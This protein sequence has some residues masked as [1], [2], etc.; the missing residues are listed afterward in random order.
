M[1]LDAKDT[2]SVCVPLVIES[3]RLKDVELGRDPK[4]RGAIEMGGI[5]QII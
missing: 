1:I 5:A 3:S 2:S 4:C